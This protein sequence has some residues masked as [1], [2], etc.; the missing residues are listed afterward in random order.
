MQVEHKTMAADY[1]QHRT[2]NPQHSRE[3]QYWA[4]QFDVP[5][6]TLIDVVREVGRNVAEVRKRLATG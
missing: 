5:P 2:I 1:R 4:E 3:V 6:S